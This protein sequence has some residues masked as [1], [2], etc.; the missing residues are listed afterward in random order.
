MLL[1]LSARRGS[2][3]VPIV[4]AALLTIKPQ[5]GFLIPVI[6][7][8]QRRWGAIVATAGVVLVLVA[9]SVLVFGLASWSSYVSDTL[10]RLDDLER[11]G[12]GL[13]MMMIPS[14]FMALRIVTGDGDLAATLHLVFAG[15]VGAYLIWRLIVVKDTVA[16]NALVLIGTVLLAPYMHSYDL[17]LLL[18]GA[19]LV[20]RLYA[21]VIWVFLL[22]AIACGLPQFVLSAE[23]RRRAALAAPHPAA[24]DPRRTSGRALK[25][26]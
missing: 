7:A 3:P 22:V 26:L 20:A 21:G 24:P 6:W 2:D 5:A 11:H 15:A 4:A 23:Y 14:A 19:L 8:V 16:R 10:P 1:A 9:L 25:R 12:T 18:A 13:F 17:A